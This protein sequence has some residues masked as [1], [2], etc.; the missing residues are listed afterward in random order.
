M[1]KKFHL[2]FFIGYALHSIGLIFFLNLSDHAL[3]FWV[4]SLILGI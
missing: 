4:I 1:F 2:Y 3:S